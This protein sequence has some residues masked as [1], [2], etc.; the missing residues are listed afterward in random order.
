MSS[1]VY[2]TDM[3]AGHKKSLLDKVEMLFDQAGF[4]EIIKEGDLVAVKLHFGERGNTAYIRPQFLR[5]IVHKIKALGGKPFLTDA[6]TL[7]LGGR[8]NAVDHLQ[9]AV[10]NGFAYAVVDA[11]LV[12]ADGLTGKDFVSVEVNRKR[13]R[14]VK[15]GSAAYHADALLA[16]THFKGHEMT[17]FGGVLKNIGMGLG[18]RSGKQMMHSD[19]LPAVDPASCIGCSKCAQWCP[20]NAIGLRG[21]TSVVNEEKCVGCGECTVTCPTRAIKISWKSEPEALQEKMVEFAE[22]ALKNKK[23]KCGFI[24]FLTNISPQCDCYGWSDAPLVRDIGIL[25]SRDPVAL[26]QASV[27]LVNGESVLPNNSLEGK[28]KAGDKFRT[29][30]PSV[31]WTRQLV[32][33]EEIG[34]GT[35]SYELVKV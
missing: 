30:Y 32:Y 15:I 28:E 20:V 1:K 5:R 6:N 13:C 22:G 19:V 33:A 16:V 24:T 8:A 35:R 12:I 17:G 21:K 9:T 27:D 14:E 31:D 29:L 26:D 7:Y 25:A 34:L 2:F 23:G 18:S 10:E 11:P 4:A 3:R